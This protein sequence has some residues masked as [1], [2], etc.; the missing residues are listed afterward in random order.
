MNKNQFG[1]PFWLSVFIGLTALGFSA[2]LYLKSPRIAYVRSHDLISKYKGTLEAQSMFQ[3]KKNGL[4]ANA[5]SLRSNFEQSRLGYTSNFSRLSANQRS[6]QEEILRQQQ[7][8]L[9]KYQAAIDQKI[10]E[11]DATMMDG[12]LG[13]V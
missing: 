9:I 6:Q 4:L 8:Q 2:A 13:Q 5:D 3:K 10:E 12:V 7:A 1:W 11:E